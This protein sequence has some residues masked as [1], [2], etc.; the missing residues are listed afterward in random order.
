MV[1][2][3]GDRARNWIYGGLL[4]FVIGAVCCGMGLDQWR[5]RL[6]AVD[7][8]AVVIEKR[9]GHS[10]SG[11]RHF[12]RYRFTIPGGRTFSGGGA[13]ERSAWEALRE[14]DEIAVRYHDSSPSKSRLRED[15]ER[16]LSPSAYYWLARALAV[17]GTAVMAV[18]IGMRRRA[19]ALNSPASGLR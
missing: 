2:S 13:L 6:D 17:A 19:R 4:L 14:G 11:A 10:R 15:Q 12:V 18:G 3:A 16:D 8:R 5:Y 9:L 7:T 1:F